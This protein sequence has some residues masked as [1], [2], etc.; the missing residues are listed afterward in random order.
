MGDIAS[1]KGIGGRTTEKERLAKERLLL[2]K[3]REL[4][5]RQ[6]SEIRDECRKLQDKYDRQYR[7]SHVAAI[8]P[9]HY[10]V[11]DFFDPKDDNGYAYLLRDA[12]TYCET[13]DGCP[14]FEERC[15]VGDETTGCRG[16]WI[17]MGATCHVFAEHIKRGIKEAIAGGK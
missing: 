1:G 6:A 7:K 12:I 13:H 10:V 2:E 5:Q 9:K 8:K 15:T 14:F 3:E 11:R 4:M 17:K 16:V